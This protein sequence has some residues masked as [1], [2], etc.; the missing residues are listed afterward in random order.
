M[1]T[2]SRTAPTAAL[3]P[4]ANLL[5]RNLWSRIFLAAEYALMLFQHRQHLFSRRVIVGGNAL[6]QVILGILLVSLQA[7]AA[8]AMNHSQRDVNIGISPSNRQFEILHGIAPTWGRSLALEQHHGDM[9]GGVLVADLR[10]LLHYWECA[11]EL[12]RSHQCLS[13]AIQAIRLNLSGEQDVQSHQIF[14]EIQHDVLAA[15]A[16]RMGR[17]RSINSR[18]VCGRQS[19]Y[20][21]HRPYSCLL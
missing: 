3:L 8:D 5:P 20:P 13:F 6:R 1:P 9:D 12:S 16:G 21:L 18:K 10:R 7:I 14:N 2:A 15:A 11:L 4:V 19:W 17:Q